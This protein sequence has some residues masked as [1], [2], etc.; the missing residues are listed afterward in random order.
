LAGSDAHGLRSYISWI[1]PK[2]RASE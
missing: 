1:V 2:V